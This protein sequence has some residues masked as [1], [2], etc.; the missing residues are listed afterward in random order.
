MS[1]KGGQIFTAV[2]IFALGVLFLIFG[3]IV[4]S[5][6]SKVMLYSFGFVFFTLVVV[7]SIYIFFIT[8]D[9]AQDFDFS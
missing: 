2:V 1:K 9:S 3:F 4:S 6:R 8:S 5:D 7:L